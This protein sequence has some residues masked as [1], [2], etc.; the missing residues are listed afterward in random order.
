MTNDRVHRQNDAIHY[1]IGF[2]AKLQ[3]I[4]LQSDF[5]GFHGYEATAT[6]PW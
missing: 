1:G 3:N 6:A 2:T 5:S 4:T